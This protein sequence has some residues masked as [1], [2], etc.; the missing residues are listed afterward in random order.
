MTTKIT[1]APADRPRT[2]TDAVAELADA[3]TAPVYLVPVGDDEAQVHVYSRHGSLVETIDVERTWVTPR[4][5][6]GTVAVH[7]PAGLVAYAARHLDPDRSTLFGDV[8]RARISVILNDHG[9]HDGD[10]EPGWADHRAVLDLKASP[11]WTAWAGAD[12]QAFAQEELAEFLEENLAAIV[13]PS[14]STMLE[15]TRTFHATTGAVFKR[16]QS[17]HSGEVRLVYEENVAATA[18]TAGETE[19]PREFTLSLRPFVGTDPVE[20]RGQ[21][22]YRVHGG[23]LSLGFRLLNLDDVRRAAVEDVLAVVADELSLVAIEGVAP[24]PRR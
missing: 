20:V 9:S 24:E 6:R 23:K 18:G 8:D 14:G 5:R 13:T 3:R 17:T 15:V 4:H 7:T 10:N 16:A 2:E 11:E 1:P 19:V 22:R 21:F 12:Q